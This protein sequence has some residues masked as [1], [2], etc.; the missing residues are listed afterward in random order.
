MLIMMKSLNILKK[1]CM[2]ISMMIQYLELKMSSTLL[3]NLYDIS[4]EPTNDYK[5][6]G[7]K[8][9]FLNL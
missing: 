6:I 3:M 1:C 5:N 9:I 4:I 2:I 8:D 7:A